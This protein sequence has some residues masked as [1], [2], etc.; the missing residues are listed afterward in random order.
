MKKMMKILLVL[1]VLL[2][3]PTV[4]NAEAAADEPAEWTVIIYLCGSDL[5]S[6]YGLAT[7]NLEE[8][9]R[10]R[11][12]V[13]ILGR[14]VGKDAEEI[15]GGSVKT[16]GTVN[17][18]IETGGSRIW[19]ADKLGIE[20]NPKRLQRWVLTPRSVRAPFILEEELPLSNMADPNTLGDFIRWSAEK[21]P[22]KRYALVLW[23]HG[24]GSKTGIIIDEL[25]QGDFMSLPELREALETGGV[26]FEAVLL[27]ACMMANVETAYVLMDYADWM[28]ASE[29]AVTGRGAAYYDWIQR[30]FYD[31]ECDGRRL[32]RWICDTAMIKASNEPDE[33]IRDL[34]TWSVIDLSNV[35]TL[36]E[37]LDRYF[38]MLGIV[39]ER[40][41]ALM[42]I[43]AMCMNNSEEFGN[44]SENM[45]DISEIFYQSNMS[46]ALDIDLRRDIL[47]ALTNTVAYSLRG[48]GRS[49]AYGLSFCYAAGFSP[50]ELEIYSRN[51]PFPHYLAFLDALS[52]W[53][54]PEWVYT[55]TEKLPEISTLEAY[56]IH[57]VKGT[58]PD[59]TPSFTVAG[60]G[61]VGLGYVRYNL[62]RLDPKTEQIISLGLAPAYF[63]N[64]TQ[65]YCSYGLWLWPSIDG[66][67]CEVNIQ[68]FPPRDNYDTLF[69]IP[70]RINTKVWNLRCGYDAGSGEY[71]VYG[72]WAGYD[73][74]TDMFNRNVRSLAQVSG[75][76]Y[77]LLYDVY[78]SSTS[79][80]YHS[81]APRS[82]FRNLRVE[83]ITLPPGTYYIE[84]IVYDLFMRP[85]RLGMTELQW[86]GEKMS[87][88]EEDWNGT[89][90][91]QL[92]NTK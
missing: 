53:E 69:N 19:H 29:E 52:I 59:G 22:A 72:L 74:D 82:I 25:Y 44:G 21:Y 87:F 35:D 26:H 31:P 27:D 24:G 33:Q 78:G 88:R 28:I 6:E 84:F 3:F 34:I 10:V 67:L 48:S 49:H 75:Q 43:Y 56:Q 46:I 85:I 1:A 89:A 15:L 11:E 50:E 38:K 66:E 14:I 42:A 73:S 32:G 86:D 5:E 30:L 92:Q 20:I 68:N 2:L 57:I 63:D 79:S 90:N 13:N 58:R 12:P 41:P 62:Y 65:E 4:R 51:C 71:T 45:W 91:L 60:D 37:Y 77:R 83:E 70:I 81:S 36:A 9:A 23:D 18:L 54:A 76:E 8:I 80:G 39:Y 7:S 61:T 16:A 17:V 40:Y 55:Y 47:D 64:N